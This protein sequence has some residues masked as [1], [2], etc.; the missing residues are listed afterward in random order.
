MSRIDLQSPI[1]I[2]STEHFHCSLGFLKPAMVRKKQVWLWNCML[3]GQLIVDK[4]LA[5][6]HTLKLDL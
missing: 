2:S 5:S 4:L 1:L 3:I 6:E